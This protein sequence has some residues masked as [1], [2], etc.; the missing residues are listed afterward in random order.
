M[1]PIKDLFNAMTKNIATNWGQAKVFML[2]HYGENPGKMLVHT[3]TLGWIL[4]SLAQVGAV[5]FNDKIPS[6]QKSYLIPQEIADAAVNI[7]SFYVLTNS[8]K[9]FGSKLVSTGKLRTAKIKDFLE[10]NN[11]LDRV[12]RF[13]FDIADP[14]TYGKNAKGINFGPYADS[15][16]AF[17]NGVDV[18]ASTT[19][20]IISC[21]LVTPILRNEFAANQQKKVLAAK[22]QRQFSN[23]QYPKGITIEDYQKLAA[24]KFS[25]HSGSMKI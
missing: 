22:Q 17:K 25:A 5:V 14:L 8:V 6:E 19:G 11:I 7:L 13:N 20:S 15:Y 12:G 3:G 2:K 21:N 18:I 1:P 4:S 16:R 24:M 23:M 9:S 10:K